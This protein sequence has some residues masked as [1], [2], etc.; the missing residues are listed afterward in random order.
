MKTF[1]SNDLRT[2][3]REGVFVGTFCAE[4]VPGFHRHKPTTLKVLMIPQSVQPLTENYRTVSKRATTMPDDAPVTFN[5]TSFQ[6]FWM[7][8]HKQGRMYLLWR[9][10][11]RTNTTGN[12]TGHVM[13]AQLSFL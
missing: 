2:V 9:K 3:Y 5:R 12:V 1:P 11:F 4:N 6:F 8:G 7:Q 13:H 10:I